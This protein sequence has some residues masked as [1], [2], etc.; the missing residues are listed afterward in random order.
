MLTK[1]LIARAL[2]NACSRSA[3]LCFMECG[4]RVYK[5]IPTPSDYEPIATFCYY[6][7]IHNHREF[8]LLINITDIDADFVKKHS[9]IEF[10][11]GDT[12]VTAGAIPLSRDRILSNLQCRALVKIRMCDNELRLKV[13]RKSL[14]GNTCVADIALNID[15]DIIEAKFPKDKW[16]SLNDD[17]YKKERIKLSFYKVSDGL[18]VID[19][20]VLQQAYMCINDYNESDIEV[21]INATNPQIMLLAEKLALL[22]YALEGHLIAKEDYVSQMRYYKTYLK[23]G[24]WYWSYWSCKPECRAKR[25]PQGSIYILSIST[26]LKHPTD[27]SSFYVKYHTKDGPRDIIFKTVERS[28]DIWTD[29]IYLFIQNMREYLDQ[30]DDLK[31][32]ENFVD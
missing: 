31:S 22:S 16:Y 2:R 8:N 17:P 4:R 1:G 13:Y 32:L 5:A 27:Y 23:D 29:S 19:N 15:R 7:G 9:V 20:I 3:E 25:N 11:V 10:E 12:K 24:K 18:N 21:K 14:V 6:T 26:I 30:F 28:R